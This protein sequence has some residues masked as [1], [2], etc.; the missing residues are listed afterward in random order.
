MDFLDLSGNNKKKTKK[1]EHQN[2]SL[3]GKFIRIGTVKNDKITKFSILGPNS[4]WRGRK[5]NFWIL[6]TDIFGSEPN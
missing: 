5:L 3:G 2:H 4:W 1:N 6:F